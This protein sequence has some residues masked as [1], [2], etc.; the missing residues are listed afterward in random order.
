MT[1]ST[2]AKCPISRLDL[3]DQQQEV[4]D[5]I[6]DDTEGYSDEFAAACL[7]D[8]F[9]VI[10]AESVNMHRTARCDCRG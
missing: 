7:R 6:L 9:L 1:T 5:M 8:L 4:V 10:P 3:Q 2:E